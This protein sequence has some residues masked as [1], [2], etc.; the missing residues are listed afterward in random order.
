MY[1][2]NLDEKELTLI[3]NLLVNAPYSGNL[4]AIAQLMQTATSLLTK[5]EIATRTQEDEQV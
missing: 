2:L 1:T 5:I 3:R 4:N